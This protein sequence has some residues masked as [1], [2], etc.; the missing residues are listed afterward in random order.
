MKT[1]FVGCF[2][3]ISQILWPVYSLN[4]T[5]TIELNTADKQMYMIQ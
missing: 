1:G 3:I 2:I 4:D 5:H